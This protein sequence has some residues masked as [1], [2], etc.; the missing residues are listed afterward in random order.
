MTK[1]RG[2]REFK[3]KSERKSRRATRKGII[4]ATERESTTVS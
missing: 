3:K 2:R 4:N 1:I